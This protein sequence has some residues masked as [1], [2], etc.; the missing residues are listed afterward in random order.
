MLY[1]INFCLDEKLG[2]IVDEFILEGQV[3]A[4]G[5]YEKLGFIKEGEMFYDAGIPHYLMRKKVNKN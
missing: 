4:M 1:M 3:Q 2:K 5:F